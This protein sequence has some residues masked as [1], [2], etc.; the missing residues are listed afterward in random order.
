M[1]FV[2]NIGYRVAGSPRESDL[3]HW[4]EARL[5]L[6][7]ACA[8]LA[9]VR[10]AD[11]DVGRLRAI[12]ARIRDEAPGSDFE[13]VRQFSDLNAQFHRV[14]ASASRNPFLERAHDQIWLGA[15]FSR[16]RFR[17]AVDHRQIVA[18]HE[19]IITA[20]SASDAGAAA[21]AMERHIVD[22][23]GRDRPQAPPEASSGSDAR[24]DE[25]RMR[26][27]RR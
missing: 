27:K 4:M 9:A 7:V 19:A 2:D 20:L 17:R 23:L 6:E 16:V 5:P 3:L 8:R 18:E 14:I 1:S 12:N 25:E 22:S 10:I 13:G 11:E 26:E 24:G 21:A 15:H